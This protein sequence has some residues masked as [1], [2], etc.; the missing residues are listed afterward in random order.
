M[1]ATP[2]SQ[3]VEIPRL[4]ELLKD[5]ATGQVVQTVLRIGYPTVAALATP[6]RPLEEVIVLG[7]RPPRTISADAVVDKATSVDEGC[8][9][10]TSGL[11]QLPDRLD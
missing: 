8:G 9:T 3:V 7:R 5:T 4:R 6:R 10:T 11:H 1:A 2:L